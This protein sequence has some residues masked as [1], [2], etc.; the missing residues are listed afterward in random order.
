MKRAGGLYAR[1]ADMNTLRLA[2]AKARRGKQDRQAVQAFAADLDGNLSRLC[3]DLRA[4]RVTL[5]G[6]R[7]FD[8]RDP[9]SRRFAAPAF[10]DR[11]LHHAILHVLEPELER[12]AVFDSYACRTGRHRAL[13]RAQQHC[14]RH[15]WYLQLDVRKYFDSVDHDVLKRLLARRLKDQPL[16]KLLYAIVDSHATAPGKGLPIGSLTSQH[17]AN[18]YLTPLDHFVPE[19]LRLGAYVRYMDD[20]VCFADDKATLVAARRA[21]EGFLR[22]EL[23]LALKHGGALDRTARGIGFLGMLV[24]GSHVRLMS[25]TKRR[26]RRKLKR[27]VAQ[28]AAGEVGDRALAVRATALLARTRQVAARGL[29]RRWLAEF[30][31]VEA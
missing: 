18:F 23:Q 27:L 4:E 7:M 30:A 26:V 25:K 3:A 19:R 15:A 5:R 22:D 8:I 24:R 28:Y 6:Y 10:A 31:D 14:R 2:F 20:F 13:A 21:I 1:I 11:V 17:L 16:L 9:K 12:V 29:R